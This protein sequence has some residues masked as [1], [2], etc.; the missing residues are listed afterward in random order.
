[1]GCE[2]NFGG[3]S[4]PELALCREL[5]VGGRSLPSEL[6]EFRRVTEVEL[7]GAMLVVRMMAGGEGM[8]GEAG[9]PKEEGR[10]R[11]GVD[12]RFSMR[13][14]RRSFGDFFCVACWW[15]AGRSMISGGEVGLGGAGGDSTGS[16]GV[17]GATNKININK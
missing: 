12:W 5:S 13:R 3:A 17:E 9:E 10:T 2:M 11:A 7:E 8:E 14:I 1:M 6:G 4:K 16:R 15:A